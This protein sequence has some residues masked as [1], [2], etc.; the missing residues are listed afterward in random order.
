MFHIEYLA[1]VHAVEVTIGGFFSEA[2][3]TRFS[4]A[5]AA[6]LAAH[7]AVRAPASLYN[8]T[9]AAIQSQAVIALFQEQARRTDPNRCVALYTEGRLARLQ[10][11][12]VVAAGPNHQVF[13]TRA[14]ALAWLAE[15]AASQAA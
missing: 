3:V 10:A 9:D 5:L 2:E 15:P 14:Q 12:R 13:D 6:E 11:A 8:Y 1:D 7:S 4:R